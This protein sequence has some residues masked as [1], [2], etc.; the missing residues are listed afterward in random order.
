MINCKM[1]FLEEKKGL[2]ILCAEIIRDKIR[3]FLPIGFT[4]VEYSLFLIAIDFNYDQGY[5]WQEV[6]GTIWYKDRTWSER[7]EYDGSEWWARISYPKIPEDL[8]VN[9]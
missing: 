1:E 6:C 5:G 8:L 7:A 4:P 3:A 2:D 9:I